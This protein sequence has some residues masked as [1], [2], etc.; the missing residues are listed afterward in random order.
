MKTTKVQILYVLDDGSA[1]VHARRT[2]IASDSLY[3]QR[4]RVLLRRHC[5]HERLKHFHAIRAAEFRFGRALGMRH[6]T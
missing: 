3:L 1:S 2:S 4:M 5:T 6:H